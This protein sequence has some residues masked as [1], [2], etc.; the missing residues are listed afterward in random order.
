[1]RRAGPPSGSGQHQLPSLSEFDMMSNT[2]QA[3][4]RSLDF[5]RESIGRPVTFTSGQFEGRTIRAEL[6]ELQ[7]ADLGRNEPSVAMC[8][9]RSLSVMRLFTKRY[10]G[11]ALPYSARVFPPYARKDRRPLD[12][13]PV[14]QLRLFDVFNSGTAFETHKEFDTYDER[15]FGLLC[16]I[17]LFP[18]PLQDDGSGAGSSSQAANT[19]QT[20]PSTSVNTPASSS[21]TPSTPS[22]S[23]QYSH[24][25]TATA[26]P[27][28][29]HTIGSSS[30]SS[31][32]SGLVLP[33]PQS[34]NANTYTHAPPPHGGVTLPPISSLDPSPSGL[35]HSMHLPPMQAPSDFPRSGLT[36][37]PLTRQ[38]PALSP[39]SYPPPAPPGHV[40]HIQHQQPPQPTVSNEGKAMRAEA[41][42]PPGVVAYLNG[43]AIKE[44]DK[45]TESLVGARDIAVQV[46]GSF[47]LRYR[48]FNLF[49]QVEGAMDIPILAEC[50]GGPFRIY[51]TKEFPGLRPSTELTKHLSLFGVRLNLRE[52]E[53]KRRRTDRS[54]DPASPEPAG[55]G[56]RGGRRGRGR[57]D[58]ED[59]DDSSDD[60]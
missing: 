7:K 5:S 1:M 32:R 48:V 13:P 20:H 6:I 26:N 2:Y 36:L 33:P 43:H 3:P 57:E 56:R 37:P 44:D 54:S 18:V 14:V 39:Y 50:Y 19:P 40:P 49:A 11:Y 38:Q 30:S 59:S 46:E 51:S 15:G 55:R 41:S 25:H 12:P 8:E 10:R 28:A 47:I 34:V 24:G 35:F 45:C 29:L 60:D 58:A 23:H 21:P 27:Y 4:I 16:H 22:T 9:P 31:S 42:A 53:R 17:D 52:T